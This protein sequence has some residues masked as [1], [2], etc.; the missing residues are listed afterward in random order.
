M[1]YLL[2]LAHRWVGLSIAG[3]LVLAGCTGSVISWDHEIDAFLNSHLTTVGSIGTPL[4]AQQLRE[5]VEAR[6]ARRQVTYLPLAAEPGHSLSMF[7]EGRFD[8]KTGEPS[9]LGY[10]QVFVDPISGA[11]LG[12]REWGAAWPI[13][14]ET[15]VSFLYKLH[16]TLHIPAM[17]GVQDWGTWLMGGVAVLWTMDCFVGFYLTLPVA[18]TRRANRAPAVADKLSRGWWSR[19][20]PA[21]T[22]KT[23]GSGYRIAFDIHRAVGLWIWSLLFLIAFT[24]FALSLH[25]PVFL[26]LVSALTTLTPS[27]AELRSASR[28]ASPA[29]KLD[30]RAIEQL[31]NAAAP[32]RGIT[33]PLGAIGYMRDISVYRVS[34][35]K[36]GDEHGLGGAGV[37]ETYWDAADGSYLGSTKPWSGTPGD[38]FVQAQLPI[39]SGRILGLV[40]R[41]AI[42][43]T[44]VLVAILAVT[45][46]RIW[47]RKYKARSIRDSYRA[48]A[49]VRTG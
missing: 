28:A 31:A 46:V 49:H 8:T 29:A 9:V 26:P 6:D 47:W 33:A 48:R 1:R 2:T 13:T 21:W 36:P 24:A 11:E 18:H 20:R 39:H 5:R 42:S 10:N 14:R 38:I 45:G 7:V 22:I 41:V 35:F 17:W 12:T 3:F 4:S 43:A 25:R 37:P 30:F 23:S 32:L 16:Y 27:P 34:Y 19:W 15:F 40:G 44:G